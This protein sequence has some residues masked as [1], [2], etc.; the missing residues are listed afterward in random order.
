MIV[1]ITNI[2]LFYSTITEP[3]ELSSPVI[4]IVITF[5]NQHVP[6]KATILKSVEYKYL[7]LIAILS[8]TKHDISTLNE[9]S[10]NYLLENNHFI[11]QIYESKNLDI[12][13]KKYKICYVYL[14]NKRSHKSKQEIK[15]GKVIPLHVRCGPEGG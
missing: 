3:Y 4:E 2:R 8:H 5:N 14:C 11:R 1:F 10:F 12:L 9:E 6:L 15:K 7:S 13:F